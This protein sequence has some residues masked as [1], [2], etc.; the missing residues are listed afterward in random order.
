VADDHDSDVSVEEIEG[1]KKGQS[2]VE[3][4]WVLTCGPHDLL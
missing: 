1:A 4:E 2:P 3:S